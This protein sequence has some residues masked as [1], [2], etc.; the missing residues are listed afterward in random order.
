[1]TKNIMPAGTIDSTTIFVVSPRLSKRGFIHARKLPNNTMACPIISK[2]PKIVAQRILMILSKF[3]EKRLKA[4]IEAFHLE[5]KLSDWHNS[6]TSTLLYIFNSI[7]V[8]VSESLANGGRCLIHVLNWF[9]L[10]MREIFSEVHREH[11]L[12]SLLTSLRPYQRIIKQVVYADKNNFSIF[13]DRQL[14]SS[15]IC[16]S[17]RLGRGGG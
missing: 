3:Y 10:K 8:K 12:K 16:V 14:E 7:V 15:L 13:D 2:D 17:R 1:M 6:L 4:L 9:G 5:H 11:R